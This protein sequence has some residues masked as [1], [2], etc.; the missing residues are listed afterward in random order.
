MKKLGKKLM[1]LVVALAMIATVIP[2]VNAEA[3]SSEKLTMYVGEAFYTWISGN[4]VQSVSSSNKS[5]V[6][7]SKDKDYKRQVNFTAKKAG[8]ATITVKYKDYNNKT[9]TYKITVTVKKLSF[10]TAYIYES[11]S[12]IGVSIKNKTA[13]TFDKILLKYTFK[14]AAGAVIAQGDQEVVYK[15]PAG[16]TVYHKILVGSSNLDL[17]DLSQSSVKVIAVEHDPGYT[18]KDVSSKVKVSVKDENKTESNLTFKLTSRNTTSQNVIGHNYVLLY[19]AVG[20]LLGVEE[21]SI[22]LDKKET[23]TSSDYYISFYSYPTYDHYEI[24]TIAYYTAKK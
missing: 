7:V 10:D 8:K 15:V 20:T 19:D 6:K 18:Y 23:K 2:V 9:K 24:V 5:V 4:G 17:I 14:D 3:A 12:C 11:G 21:G 22:Y 1:A 13:Q 16:K